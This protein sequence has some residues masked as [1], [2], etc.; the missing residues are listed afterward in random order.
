S[1]GL[2]LRRRT[3]SAARPQAAGRP[4]CSNSAALAGWSRAVS[5]SCA[6]VVISSRARKCRSARSLPATGRPACCGFLVSLTT[7]NFLGCGSRQTEGWSWST[8]LGS[9]AA[10]CSPCKQRS[11]ARHRGGPLTIYLHGGD[12]AAYV[13]TAAPDGT[14]VH[15]APGVRLWVWVGPMGDARITDLTDIDGQPIA[16]VV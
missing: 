12:L 9:S 8:N 16:E 5:S 3:G 10:T 11:G 15:F 7:S 13:V 6:P 14:E 1:G 2:C 4:T